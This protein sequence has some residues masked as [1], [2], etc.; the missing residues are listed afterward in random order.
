[1]KYFVYTL[2]FTVML[3]SFISCSNKNTTN[4]NNE[5]KK[6]NI[7]TTIFPEYDW[8]K[9][10]VGDKFSQYDL[11]M[12]YNTGTDLHSYQP[13]ADDIIKISNSDIFIYVGGESD[14]WIEEVLSKSTNKNMTVINLL[15][16]LG[17]SAKEEEHVEGMQEE[18]HHHD[19][20][21]DEGHHEEEHEI[22]YDEHV[23]LS[24][25]NAK[26]FVEKIAE[27]ICQK[28]SKNADVYKNNAANYIA[29]LN[30]L[31]LQYKNI[32]DSSAKKTILFGDRFPFRYLVDDYGLKYY[33]AFA[34][35]S[36]E[37][38]A[39]FETIIFLAN[40]ADELK[41]NVILTIEGTNHKIA[42]TIVQNTKSKNQEILVM[43]SM[44]ST[45][46]QDVENG[47]SYISIMKQNLDVLK[48]ALK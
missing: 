45:A 31:D 10:I 17:S 48:Q 3:I 12:L 40:K 25:K 46:A 22:E 8:V 28:D 44:Q 15:E 27:V 38:E 37:S 9:N 30:D 33:A 23:W 6:I 5:N 26:I 35:C 1:M 43:N 34:G 47:I 21:E 24:L 18:E 42:Q 36:A 29:K 13:T 11:T 4:I 7:V 39:A 19:G 2:L 20:D 32:V 16:V 14:E 41:L